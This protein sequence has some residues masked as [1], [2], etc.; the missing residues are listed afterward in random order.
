MDILRDRGISSLVILIFNVDYYCYSVESYH[1]FVISPFTSFYLYVDILK[2]FR[3]HI[4][5]ILWNEAHFWAGTHKPIYF[6]TI[7]INYSEGQVLDKTV[8]LW[9]IFRESE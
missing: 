1:F 9:I 4:N 6:G 7:C 3:N 8:I 5:K 2:S